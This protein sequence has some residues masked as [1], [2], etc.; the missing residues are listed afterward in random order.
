MTKKAATG[1]RLSP[2]PSE[3]EAPSVLLLLLLL[4][5]V[6]LS[7]LLI[8]MLLLAFLLLLLIISSWT[9]LHLSRAVGASTAG[10]GCREQR[11]GR[12]SLPQKVS[13]AREEPKKPDPEKLI[14]VAFVI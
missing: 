14:L 1:G 6:L 13:R 3:Q 4:L 12:G 2:K 10:P 8:L 7:V 9:P 11:R 5:L